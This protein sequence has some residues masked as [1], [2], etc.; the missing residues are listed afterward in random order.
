M[1]ESRKTWSPGWRSSKFI[2]EFLAVS[3]LSCDSGRKL[4]HAKRVV[5]RVT[6]LIGFRQ[7]DDRVFLYHYASLALDMRGAQSRLIQYKGSIS[8]FYV[9]SLIHNVSSFV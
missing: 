1:L 7:D 8:D 3:D 6:A 5:Y 4:N 9:L 2:F